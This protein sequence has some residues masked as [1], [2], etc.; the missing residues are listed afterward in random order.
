MPELVRY[1]IFKDGNFHLIKNPDEFRAMFAPVD[2]ADEALSFTLALTDV[3]AQYDQKFN[4]KYRYTVETL[5]DTHVDK[6]SDGYIVHASDYQFFGC[7]P[8]YYYAVDVMV[9]PDGKVQEILR[10]K[11]YRDPALDDLCQD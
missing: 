8:H 3:Y 6:T 5:E 10:T 2:S 1:V 11:I 4:R 7:G 9:S